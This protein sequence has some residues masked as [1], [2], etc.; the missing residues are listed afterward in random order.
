MKIIKI[1]GT[2]P[3]QDKIKIARMAMKDGSIII[4]PTDTVYGIGANVFDE[5]AILKI[6]SIKKRPLNK[7]L[8]ICISRIE[9]IKHVAKMDVKA[10]TIIRN[11]LPGPFTIILKKNANISSL[12]TAGSDKI[13]IRIPDNR[14]CMDLSREFPITSTSA[15]L[16]GYDIPESSEGVIKQLGSSIDI[17]MDAGICKH[18]IPSTV[19]DM[20]VYP[21]KVLR[22]GAG[23]ICL[24]SMV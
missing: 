5:K 17:M 22:E 16:S 24:E 20:T 11:L 2:N 6:F 13:G 10:E 8:S 23:N 15:N 21:P 14:V 19:I 9:D 18:G 4:Y 7:P 12:L 3:D 1:D